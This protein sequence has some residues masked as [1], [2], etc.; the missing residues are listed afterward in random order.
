M[1]ACTK[2]IIEATKEVCQR[3]IKETIKY[4]FIFDSWLSSNNSEEDVM[5]VGADIIYMVKTNTKLFYKDTIENITKDW[6]GGYYLVLSRKP[7]VSQ[8]QAAN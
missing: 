4:C 7:E 1:T 2:R 8:G 5:D 6:M 3:D